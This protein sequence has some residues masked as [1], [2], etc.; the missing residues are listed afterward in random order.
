MQF[1]R[2]T[3]NPAQMRG[4]PCIRGLRIPVSTVVGLVAQGMPETQIMKE[5]PDLDVEDI[6]QSLRFAAAAVDERQLP[7]LTGT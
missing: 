7:L 1:E 6:R 2:I 5:Y 4:V 3:I